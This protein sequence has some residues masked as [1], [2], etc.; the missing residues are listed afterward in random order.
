MINL[1]NGGYDVMLVCG[2]LWSWFAGVEKG[3]MWL[4]NY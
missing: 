4:S 3:L 2:C 1:V